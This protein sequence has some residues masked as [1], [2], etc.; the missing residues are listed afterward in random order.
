M[1]QQ[2][3]NRVLKEARSKSLDAARYIR[4]LSHK[5][6]PILFANSFPKSGTNLLT[7]ILAGFA[8]VNLFHINTR[9]IIL[10]YQGATGEKRAESEILA[11]IKRIYPGEIAWGHMHGTRAITNLLLQSNFINFFIFRDPRDVVVS[12]AYYVTNKANAHVHHDYYQDK[13]SSMEERIL[14]SILGLPDLTT[15]FP[16]IGERFDPYR[17]WLDFPE[18]MKLKFEDLIHDRDQTLNNMLDHIESRGYKLKVSRSRALEQMNAGIA[19]A[20]SRTFRKGSTGDWKVQF[21]SE[22][23]K[24]FKSVTGNLLVELGY[25][26][27]NQW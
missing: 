23:K 9:G 14:T 12:H 13:L 2:P 4:Y 18:V 20:A 6:A 27:N 21:T 3:I 17:P 5:H 25:E 26:E 8:E 24:I 19:P 22:H 16:N 15:E 7:Q 11:D 1:M 10:T